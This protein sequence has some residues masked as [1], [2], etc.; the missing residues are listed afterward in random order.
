MNKRILLVALFAANLT[1]AQ[2]SNDSTQVDAQKIQN[3]AQRIISNSLGKKVTLGGYGEITYNQ[4]EGDNGELDVQRLVLL[5]GYNFNDVVQ[6]VSEIEL[7]H[8]SE[9]FV[10]QAFINYSMPIM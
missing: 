6:F 8:V 1:F 9:V 2:I 3:S 10:E 5:V 7:E 4:P